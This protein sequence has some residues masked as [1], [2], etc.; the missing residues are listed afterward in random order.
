[1]SHLSIVI[2][3]IIKAQNCEM[4]KMKFLI[5]SNGGAFD[6]LFEKK[7]EKYTNFQFLNEFRNSTNMKITLGF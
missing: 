4:N 6:R 3:S 5:D 1:M 2:D 7:S